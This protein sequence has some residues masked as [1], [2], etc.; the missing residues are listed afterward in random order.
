MRLSY[1]AVAMLEGTMALGQPSP[2]P[3]S[4]PVVA[5]EEALRAHL[6]SLLADPAMAGSRVGALVADVRTGR[7]LFSLREHEALN[8]ASNVKLATTAA[9]LALLGPEYRF[10]TVLSGRRV[11]ATVRGN[12]YLRG[13]GDPTLVT[14]SIH[15]LCADLRSAGIRQIERGVIVDDSFFAPPAPAGDPPDADA[16]YRASPTALSLNYNTVRVVVRPGPS[17]GAAAEVSVVP[18][19]AYFSTTGQVTTVARGGARVDLRAGP[20]GPAA[21]QASL[22]LSGRI[23]LSAAPVELRRRVPAPALYAGHT[24]LR[25]L[26]RYGIQVTDPTV[27]AGQTPDGLAL[28]ASHESDP[29]SVLIRAV[30]KVSNNVMADQILL[31]IGAEREGAPGTFA[32]GLAAVGDHLAS[33]G[34]P[35]DG[36]RL[37]SGSGLDTDTRLS[38]ATLVALLRASARDFRY[39]ADFM[40]SLAVAGA[41]GTLARRLAASPAQR[42]VRAKTGTLQ[43]VV[44]LSGYVAGPLR[45]PLCFAV[46]CNDVPER[47]DAR[48]VA[49]EFAAALYAYLAR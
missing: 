44:T 10:R 6:A 48:R 16:A 2:P 28:L 43:G 11:G 38:A 14:E 32:K 12:L 9:G 35:R 4:P 25:V 31:A 8:P 21:E 24:L 33:L 29:L 47:A 3:S 1:V 34:I 30:N 18:D 49:D 41:D 19:S 22:V 15:T 13:M 27:R 23:P 26:A 36:F 45:G 17:E 5:T 46:L 40:A 39:A 37:A 42:Y 20:A 7:V